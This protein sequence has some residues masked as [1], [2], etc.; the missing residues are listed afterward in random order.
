MPGGGHGWHWHAIEKLDQVLALQSYKAETI[1]E[2]LNSAA[3]ARGV[4]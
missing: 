2:S 3:S 1:T 4:A